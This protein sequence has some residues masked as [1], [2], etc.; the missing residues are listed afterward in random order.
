MS[1][2]SAAREE[3]GQSWLFSPTVTGKGNCGGPGQVPSLRHGW[4]TWLKPATYPAQ[5]LLS[6]LPRQFP[7]HECLTHF[8]LRALVS[9][10][11][12]SE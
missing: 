10:P 7:P 1:P 5:S 2:F 12:V 3:L 9:F 8:V 11:T 6:L 4:A